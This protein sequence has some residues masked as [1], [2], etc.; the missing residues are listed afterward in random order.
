M[1]TTPTS[2][3]DE[4]QIRERVEGVARA[5]RAK[6]ASALMTHYA[7]DI[8]T[9][10][11]PFQLRC[12]GI[13]AYRK[14]FEGWFAAVEGSID[15]E[16]HEVQVTIGGDVAFCHHMSRVRSTRKRP[17]KTD[18]WA[19]YWVRVT[20]GLQKRNGQWLITHEHVSVPIDMATLE[21]AR[22]LHP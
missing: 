17:E 12:Q 18:Y 2:R 11:L 5:I 6:D 20:A 4:A 7:P 14:N 21:A 13:D 3:K 1:A 9:F 10:D 8:V 16:M 22:N 19:E 15:Y